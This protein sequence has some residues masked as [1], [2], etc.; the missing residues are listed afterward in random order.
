VFSAPAP[1]VKRVVMAGQDAGGSLP[2]DDYVA[3]TRALW[4]A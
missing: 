2:R 3:A 4:S 1:A